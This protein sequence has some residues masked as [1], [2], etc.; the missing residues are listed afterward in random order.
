MRSNQLYE[1]R[2][3]MF[4]DAV[5]ELFQSDKQRRV[6]SN[7]VHIVS[8]KKKNQNHRFSRA[9]NAFNTA[10]SDVSFLD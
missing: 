2:G 7:Y 1:R 4:P 10:L 9:P 6:C 8:E 5:I 3:Q